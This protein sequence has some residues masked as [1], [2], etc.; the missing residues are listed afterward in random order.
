MRGAQIRV[1]RFCQRLS[2]VKPAA[3]K[4]CNEKLEIMERYTVIVHDEAA[5]GIRRPKY[6]HCRG[7]IPGR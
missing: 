2:A 4:L 1:A 5:G 6:L 3:F 7:A